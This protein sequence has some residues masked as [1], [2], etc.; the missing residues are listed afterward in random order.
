[1]YGIVENDPLFDVICNNLFYH[2]QNRYV[3][4]EYNE[5]RKLVYKPSRIHKVWITD[6]QS[7]QPKE[8]FSR[9]RQ[10]NWDIEKEHV[11]QVHSLIHMN[12]G[13]HATTPIFS[14]C[15]IKL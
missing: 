12:T 13:G 8:C 7:L 11:N 10:R 6:P 5:Y 2:K 4:E 9:K 3:L 1:M 14:P 15:G